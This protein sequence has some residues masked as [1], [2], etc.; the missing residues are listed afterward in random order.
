MESKE[1]H[2]RLKQSNNTN[3]ANN[4]KNTIDVYINMCVCV[5]TKR[6]IK[7]KKH[8]IFNIWNVCSLAFFYMYRYEKCLKY[9]QV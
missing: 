3:D 1:A 4:K 9:M 2:F 5:Y 7:E 8:V 6:N